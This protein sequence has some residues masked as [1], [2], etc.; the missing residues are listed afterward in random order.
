MK[1]IGIAASRIAK[2]SL[3]LYN[4]YVILI[5]FLFSLL[6]FFIS[7]FTLIIGLALISYITKGFMVI[8]PG[9]GFSS[10]LTICMVALVV[11]VGTIN[12]AAILFNIKLRK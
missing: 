3:W 7:G 9:T 12:L 5:S 4:F 8:E 1:R 6:V 2:D 11:V 10:F